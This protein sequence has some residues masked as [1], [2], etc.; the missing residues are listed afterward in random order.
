MVNSIVTKFTIGTAQGRNTIMLV[1]TENAR[2]QYN[3]KVPADELEAFI[4]NRFNDD[5]LNVEMNSMSNEYLVVYADGEPAGYARITSK[6]HRPEI[7]DKKTVIRI[8]DFRVLDKFDDIRIKKNL[9]E[10]CIDVCNRQQ[11]TWINECSENADLDFFESYG[12]IKNTEIKE[13]HELGL[14]P[15]YLVKDKTLI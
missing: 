11:V 6:G 2:E 7:F 13:P 10:K 4:R 3:G 15:A 12:F 14:N 1:G 5:V 9:F 8:A